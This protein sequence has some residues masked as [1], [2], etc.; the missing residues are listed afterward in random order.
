MS[1]APTRM[2][3]THLRAIMRYQPDQHHRRSI[4]LKDFNYASS[5]VYFITLC[6]YQR[7]C[8]WGEIRQGTMH[9]NQ[10]GQIVAAEWVKSAHIRQEVTLGN[11]VV[12]PN[13]FHAI[14]IIDRPL[15]QPIPPL[16]GVNG[17]DPLQELPDDAQ[18]LE[19]EYELPE[20]EC[21][22]PLPGWP[23]MKSRSLSALIAGF[24]S[25][26]ARLD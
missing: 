10:V 15:P 19:R 13:Y 4:R 24:K 22:S 6:T 5:A 17:I 12:M 9:L 7:Q 1:F 14:V 23:R 18:L 21:H 11:W 26:V 3:L 8:L 2:E 25:S 16:V 20:G